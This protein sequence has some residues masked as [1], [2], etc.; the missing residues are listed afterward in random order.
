MRR[1][2]PQACSE[3]IIEQL[4]AILGHQ[5]LIDTLTRMDADVAVT[6]LLQV[7][8]NHRSPCREQALAALA[9]IGS[10]AAMT[11][12]IKATTDSDAQIRTQAVAHLNKQASLPATDVLHHA[13]RHD[14]YER[15]WQ[16]AQALWDLKGSQAVDDLLLI[17]QDQALHEK[18]RTQETQS[19]IPPGTELDEYQL[20]EA[21]SS[22]DF[23]AGW[24]MARA[25][26]QFDA[27]YA[28][29]ILERTLDLIWA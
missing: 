3:A 11:G 8:N 21:L 17:L 15:R 29:Y 13:L 28:A 14:D 5:A 2:L 1:W 24:Q 12:L 23:E 9:H 18:D 6:G 22:G 20:V 19:N 26:T 16:S 7:L 4:G 10:E 25:I 27:N